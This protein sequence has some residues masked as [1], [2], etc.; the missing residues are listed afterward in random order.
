MAET[1]AGLL[2]KLLNKRAGYDDDVAWE[3]FL[4]DAYGGT[5]GFQGRV[6]MPYAG[7]WGAGSELY[8]RS[9]TPFADNIAESQLDT[10]LDRYPREELPKFHRRAAIANYPNPVEPVVDIKLS[11]LHRKAMTRAGVEGD[12]LARFLVD[13]DGHGKSWDAL[14]QDTIHVRA[15]V[16][17]AAP[18]LFDMAAADDEPTMTQARADELGLRPRAIP[19]FMAQL[20]DWHFDAGRLEWVKIGT[21]F[22]ERAD[23]LS[24]AVCVHQ[25]ACWYRDKVIT[26][27]I[28]KEKSNGQDVLRNT[29]ERP[30]KW[31][32]V[33]LVVFVHKPA[34]MPMRGH[35][36]IGSIAKLAKRLLNYGSEL[37]EHLR[38][39]TFAFLQIPTDAPDQVGGVLGG[40]GM[41]LP[42][43]TTSTTEYKFVS[44]DTTVPQVYEKRIE[45]TKKD[46]KQIARTES[47]NSE[48]KTAKSGMSR[49][50]DFENLNRAIADVAR[51]FADGDQKSLRFVAVM[52]GMPP[53]E[54]DKILVTP[55]QK[56]DVEELAN[57]IEQALSAK[58]LGIGP[59]ATAEMLKRLVRSLLPNW[60]PAQLAKADREIEEAA[61]E[62]EQ[63]KAA[64]KLMAA[65]ILE[66]D[67]DPDADPDAEPDPDDAPTKSPP[68]KPPAKKPGQKPPAPKA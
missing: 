5:G 26:Y 16:H 61:T 35:S 1:D 51:H 45:E 63:A 64:A 41:A 4:M 25:V 6:R 22:E 15:E 59:T 9:W 18:V 29:V 48:T 33:P 38:S 54:V 56:F 12:K 2:K 10:Y 28:V 53:A 19:L 30:N 37:D 24:E 31:G 46:I 58:G 34:Q 65:A 42:V 21:F 23:A 62:E 43:K 7:F 11:Y 66:E 47:T 8:A 40:Q 13:A 27:E 60:D 57:E 50:I 39:S 67:A 20:Y 52:E 17:G 3:K 32:V 44:P 14:L 55:P 68:V 36:G 49:A